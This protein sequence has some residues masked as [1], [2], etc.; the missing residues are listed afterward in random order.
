MEKLILLAILLILIIIAFQDFKERKIT[1]ILLPIILILS[2]IYQV[3]KYSIAQVIENSVVNLFVIVVQLLILTIV[4]SIKQKKIVYLYEE[5]LGWGDILFLP[6]ICIFFA[7]ITMLFFYTAC[8]LIITIV[9][10]FSNKSSNKTIP[11]AGGLSILL[12]IYLFIN[13]MWMPIHHYSDQNMLK[14]IL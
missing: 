5:M 6:I 3:K 13:E 1:A 11:L 9:Y 10:Y 14:L 2:I 4:F 8:L 12:A 7:P